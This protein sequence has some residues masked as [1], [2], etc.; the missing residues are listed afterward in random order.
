MTP[1]PAP[2]LP[3]AVP[4]IRREPASQPSRELIHGIEDTGVVPPVVVRESWQALANVFAVR[5]GVVEIVID[6]TGAVAGATMKTAVNAVYDRLAL[7]EARRWRY[8]PATLDGVPVKFR[9][10]IVLD[11]SATR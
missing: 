7:T 1:R 10:V 9:K 5:T 8:K 3:A 6:E 4:S 2:A 11:L